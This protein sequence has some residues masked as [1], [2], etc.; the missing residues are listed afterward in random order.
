MDPISLT[1]A[2]VG[3]GMSIFGG[4][5]ASNAA[6]KKAEISAQE[7]GVS[8]DVARQEQS[9]ND[10]KQ[11]AM[12]L[13]G[14]RQNM[15]TIRNV[16]RAQALALN[17][18]TNQNAQFGSGLQGGEAGIQAQGLFDIAGVNSAILSGRSIAGYNR[19]I[20]SDKE[21]L[22]A[23]GSQSAQYD[24]EIAKDQGYASLGGSLIKAGPIVGQVSQGMGSL[25]L[26]NIFMGG[27][28]PSGYGRG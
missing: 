11:Q 24:S 21:Q 7:A 17:N 13:S 4:I 2:V 5:G 3:V 16:Q 19:N 8:E 14:R 9:I 12:E 23:L 26:G 1:L 20:S 18:A 15:E 25:N 6:S 10:V 28:S 27:G 22:A